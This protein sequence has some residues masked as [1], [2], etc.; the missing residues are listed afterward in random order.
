MAGASLAG[1]DERKAEKK[2]G[3][4]LG[5]EEEE[6]R[7]RE[8]RRWTALVWR[9]GVKDITESAVFQDSD[10]ASAEISSQK[11]S[12]NN[13]KK[14]K[15]KKSKSEQKQQAQP[16]LPGASAFFYLD[17]AAPDSVVEDPLQEESRRDSCHGLPPDL[18][19]ASP[20]RSGACLLSCL[21]QLLRPPAGQSSAGQL[22]PGPLRSLW[23]DAKQLQRIFLR[24]LFPPLGPG[25][26]ASPHGW[27]Y[28]A[29]AELGAAAQLRRRLDQHLLQ[30]AAAAAVA[31]RSMQQLLLQDMRMPEGL[32]QD[33][34]ASKRALAALEAGGS[35]Y[36]GQEEQYRIQVLGVC[37]CD[38][39]GPVKVEDLLNDMGIVFRNQA[40]YDEA[41]QHYRRA[42]QIYEA[43]HGKDHLITAITLHNMG[44]VF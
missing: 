15:I 16:L 17:P 43:N 19:P 37:V 35:D 32:R 3:A 25:A 42:L 40:R 9:F 41:L 6:T 30:R 18:P 10:A 4:A 26:A 11:K 12:K 14:S 31:P 1:G 13:K 8:S 33:L 39:A 23:R 24:R 38:E 5:D 7:S 27:P 44:G 20:E 22:A 29:L 36:R 28:V 2:A 21:Q 34:V